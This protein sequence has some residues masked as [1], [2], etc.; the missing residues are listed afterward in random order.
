MSQTL[1]DTPCNNMQEIGTIR[2]QKIRDNG[3]YVEEGKQGSCVK[4]FDQSVAVI[5]AAGVGKRMKSSLPKVLH[6]LSGVPMLSYQLNLV[7]HF[8]FQKVVVVIGHQADQVKAALASHP[9]QTVLQDLPR[10]TGDA[11]LKAEPLLTGHAGPV[12]ILNGDTP[13]LQAATLIRLWEA[14]QDEKATLTL[15]TADP[16]NPVGYGRIIRLEDGTL[17]RIVEERDATPEERAVKETNAGTYIVDATFLFDA[18][19]HVSPHNQQKEYYL[20]DIVQI[21]KERGKKIA[22][23]KANSE[24]ALGINSRADL[25]NAEK[26]LQKRITRQWMDSGV[27]LIDPEQVRIEASVTIGADTVLYPGVTLSGKTTIGERSVLHACSIKDSRIDSEVLIK[28]YCVI[29]GAIIESGVTVG[30][31]AHLRPGTMLRRGAHIG[32]FVEVKKSEIGEGS[33]A[34]HLTYLGDARIGKRVNIGAG[35]ITCN[36]DGKK[37]H[38]T[39]IEDDVFVGSDTQFVAPVTIG[40]RSLIAAG[41]TITKDVEPDSLGISRTKQ[42]VIAGWTKKKRDAERP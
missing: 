23:L 29:D 20:T 40:A 22:C 15:M 2:T 18:L 41:S 5:L 31:F 3:G 13:L 36:Y 1:C 27:T 26:I 34:N 35:T 7:S 37:K 24:E 9:V 11:V 42:A 38:E 28:D 19:H 4:A 8:P 25:A 14:H 10:G 21:A 6:T 32:N 30:P 33:K 39:V 12:L 17:S 16:D